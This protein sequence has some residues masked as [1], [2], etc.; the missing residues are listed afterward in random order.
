MP[1]DLPAA[2]PVLHVDTAWAQATAAGWEIFE[3]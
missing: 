3:S 2:A 1:N